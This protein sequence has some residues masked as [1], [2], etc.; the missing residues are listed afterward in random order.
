MP[1]P[2]LAGPD[3]AHPVRVQVVLGHLDQVQVVPG[4]ARE[5]R[6]QVLVRQV[7]VVL[8]RQV[9][10]VPVRRAPAHRDQVLAVLVLV[11]QVLAVQV[12]Q[13]QVPAVPVRQA[14]AH[15]DQ[16]RAD[17]VLQVQAV[18]AHRDQAR[19]DQV[20]QAQVPARAPVQVQV[21]AVPAQVHQEA[22]GRQHRDRSFPLTPSVSAA[23]RL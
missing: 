3:Q 7:R 15:R 23:F 6:D 13:V 20:L 5:H 17:Q 19:A 11:R 12:L 2:R 16:A 14:P 9:P 1:E 21:P 8:V 4:Q 18:L 22:L 10:A